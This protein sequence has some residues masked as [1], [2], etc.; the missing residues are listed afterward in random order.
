ARK[1]F[2]RFTGIF[3]K[4][5]PENVFVRIQMPSEVTIHIRKA[6]LNEQ[7]MQGLHLPLAVRGGLV[8]DLHLTVKAS[9]KGAAEV[10]VRVE[11]AL[12]LLAPG[13]GLAEAGGFKPAGSYWNAETVR[14]AK[15]NLVELMCKHV[16]PEKEKKEPSDKDKVLAGP[17]L[18]SA[19][20]SRGVRG[21]K[22]ATSKFANYRKRMVKT[23][24][25]SIFKNLTVNIKNVRV[26]LDDSEGS[27]G[28]QDVTIGAKVASIR[29]ERRLGTGSIHRLGVF[30][31]T[32]GRE[33]AS[34]ELGQHHGGGRRRASQN[35]VMSE[36]ETAAEAVLKRLRLR[37]R[38]LTRGLSSLWQEEPSKYAEKKLHHLL[39]DHPRDAVAG[40]WGLKTRGSRRRRC[41]PSTGRGARRTPTSRNTRG[42][43]GSQR[44][45]SCS[46]C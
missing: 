1:Q 25:D 10:N 16:T 15:S 17:D 21:W 36:I 2:T 35:S 30:V 23:I 37:K 5:P 39:R 31:Q 29:L 44:G 14:E 3:L 28:L 33:R 46:R 24:L 9:L 12:L 40:P 34:R 22:A 26:Q 43:R 13:D 42:S 38:T 4:V 45:T 41:R 27:L 8:E 7:A 18:K 32:H 19:A 6:E 20:S 11:N